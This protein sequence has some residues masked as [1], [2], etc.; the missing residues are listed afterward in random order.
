[1]RV[2]HT[3]NAKRSARVLGLL[4]AC[5]SLAALA[6]AAAPLVVA[7]SEPDIAAIVKDVGGDQ[8]ETFVLFKGCILRRQLQVEPAVRQN[9]LKAD[10]IVWTGF[11]PESGAVYL[12]VGDRP[13]RHGRGAWNPLWIDVSKG[14]QQVD[15]AVASS[16]GYCEGDVNEFTVHGDPFFRLNPENG[17]V[18]ARDIVAGLAKL[19]PAEK[20]HFESNAEAFRQALASKI[21]R[22]KAELHA[23]AGMRVL[24][25]QCGWENFAKLGGPELIVCKKA[26]GCPMT[27]EEITKHAKEINAKIILL[28]PN[29]VAKVAKALREAPGAVVVEVPSSI[30]DLPGATNYA[31]IFDNLIQVLQRYAAK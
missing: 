8:V 27:P 29:T 4:L 14:A 5:W 15:A 10:A 26:P 3:G 17:A 25:T 24:C 30:G 16:C 11:L 6:T 19:R 21:V 22:W 31:A 13:A 20:A 18:M 7:V 12:A 1:M 23:L 9:L 2:P 28:D